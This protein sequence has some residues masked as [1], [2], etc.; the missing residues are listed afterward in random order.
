MK[1]ELNKAIKVEIKLLLENGEV[2]L[3]RID[4]EFIKKIASLL[5]NEL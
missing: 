3:T 2:T 1:L 5:E 4:E